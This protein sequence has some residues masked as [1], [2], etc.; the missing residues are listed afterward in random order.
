MVR[1]GPGPPGRSGEFVASTTH[2]VVVPARNLVARWTDTPRLAGVVA[3]CRTNREA[4]RGPAHERDGGCP[5]RR[6]QKERALLPRGWSSPP[7][8]PGYPCSSTLTGL[9]PGA[10]GRL[11]GHRAGAPRIALILRGLQLPR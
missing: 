9:D 10:G 2:R 11:A 8:R 3:R 6:T 7:G 4:E 1:E 5:R